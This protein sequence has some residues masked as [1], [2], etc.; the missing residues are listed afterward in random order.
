MVVTG[1]DLPRATINRLTDYQITRFQ[2]PFSLEAFSAALARLLNGH[3]GSHT[4]GMSREA[5]A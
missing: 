3:N 1:R 2:K 4:V 5:S